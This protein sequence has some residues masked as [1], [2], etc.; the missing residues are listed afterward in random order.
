VDDFVTCKAYGM[1]ND[2]I[3][4]PVQS[5]GVYAPSLEFFGGQFIFKANQPIIDK[6]SEVGALLHTETIKH[7][8]MHCWRH[9]TPLIYRA[10]AQWF[11]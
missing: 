10:T 7:S 11:I 5:N 1:V 8:Y 6:L 2:D 4:N 9:K 3:L